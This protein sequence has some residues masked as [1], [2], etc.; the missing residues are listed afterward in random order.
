MGLV[1]INIHTFVSLRSDNYNNKL[2]FFVQQGLGVSHYGLAIYMN[3]SLKAKE[4]EL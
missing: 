2:V 1:W 3:K 4:E